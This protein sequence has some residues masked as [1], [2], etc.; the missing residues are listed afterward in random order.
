[1]V[2]QVLVQVV[3]T[4]QEETVP[5]TGQHDLLQGL[6][7]VRAGA[8]RSPWTGVMTE[9]VLVLVP[10]VLQFLEQAL[11]PDQPAGGLGVD[12]AGAVGAKWPCERKWAKRSY[13]KVRTC[14]AVFLSIEDTP[15]ANFISG[16][17]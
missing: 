1:M 6:I 5:S 7:W 15:L 9:W 16:K 12:R 14:Y 3:Q 13:E 17:R 2:P 10:I 11:K 8:A 4:S